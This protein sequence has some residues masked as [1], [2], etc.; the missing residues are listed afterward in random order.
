MKRVV[1]V[2]LLVFM[3]FIATA[4][5]YSSLRLQLTP[6]LEI[7][8]GG[9]AGRFNPGAAGQ[10][11]LAYK[12]PT[13]FPVYV[14][15]DAGYSYIPVNLEWSAPIHTAMAGGGLGLDF[16]L[17]GRL[18]AD[19]YVK[20]GYYQGFIRDLQGSV[21][22]GGNP[23]LDTGAMF[24]FYLSPGF[25]IGIGS[26]YREYFG[27]PESL[28][29]SISFFLSGSYRIPLKGSAEFEPLEA[30]PSRLQLQ[31]I[32]IG[33][34]FPVFYKYYDDHPIGSAVI[35]NKEK[36]TV[37][38]IEI[39]VFMKQYMDY[40]KTYGIQEPVRKGEK[41]AI[42]LFALFNE[43]VLMITEGAKV[44]AE[45]SIEYDF[46]GNRKHV[47]RVETV[48]LQNRN[49][50]IWDDDRR[51]AAFITARDP[52][53][54][55]LGK[56]IAGMVRGTPNDVLGKNFMLLLAIHNA[57]SMY[58]ISYVIDPNTPYEEFHKKEEAIDFLQF[59]RQTLEYRAGDCDDLSILYS[60]LLEALS[61][62]TAFITAPG[63]IYIAVNLGMDE[64]EAQKIFYHTGD[65]IFREG[66]T[67]LPFE[68]TLV[69]ESFL[70]AWQE[71]AREWNRYE[72]SG[73][74]AFYPVAEAWK[75]FEPVGLPGDAEGVVLPDTK[76]VQKVFTADL[77]SLVQREIEN[78][79]QDLRDRIAASNNNS[80]L[81]NALG[82]LYAQYG[83][84]DEAEEQ[85][86]AILKKT[87]YPMAMV[88]LGNIRFIRKDF[89][90][91]M[92]YY[93]EA[94]KIYPDSPKV[95]LN[96]ARTYYELRRYEDA[97]NWYER[98]KPVSPALAD[99]YAYLGSEK[100]SGS[101]ASDAM[102][103]GKVLWEE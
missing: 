78:K 98:V 42:D 54:L 87:V 75:V 27:K 71:G 14:G 33:N 49:A 103:K 62:E 89:E 99:R 53:V 47:S 56:N 51:A 73:K 20:G 80:K 48:S 6:R 34:I 83:L 1:I 101:R 46:K 97:R 64:E 69:Q 36:G 11:S 8:L 44:S 52:I 57:L 94:L 32:E 92:E 28:Y 61:V 50:S 15:I 4:Q 60:A 30:V 17:L 85:F 86:K 26:A 23:Y 67:W 100:T 72:P 39:S 5:T 10:F 84:L 65:L 38:N 31:D 102:G 88:N 77:A 7:P 45:I 18:G 19:I 76:D 35:E 29:R 90:K 70:R 82:I 25:R 95:M 16:R 68:V 81:I 59:P 91:S 40:P 43:N 74:A 55:R 37:E 58:G 13:R 3:P 93:S 21:V 96:L 24:R 9:Y 2:I 63:H 22:H 41:R 12:P 66:K 79:L